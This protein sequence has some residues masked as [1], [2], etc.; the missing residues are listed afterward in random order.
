MTNTPTIKQELN[1]TDPLD[2]PEASLMN[3]IGLP[4]M[5]QSVPLAALSEG[6]YFPMQHE[7]H[8]FGNGEYQHVQYSR[9]S[10]SHQHYQQEAP[11]GSQSQSSSADNDQ[12]EEQHA[13]TNRDQQQTSNPRPSAA[14]AAARKK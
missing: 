2:G 1:E 12:E 11:Q 9:P 7:G 14:S 8:Q 5:A 13:E 3:G 10:E 6:P 4:M